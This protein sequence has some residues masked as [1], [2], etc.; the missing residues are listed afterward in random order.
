MHLRSTCNFI[1]Y[2][3]EVFKWTIKTQAEDS[4]HDEKQKNQKLNNLSKSEDEEL[5]ITNEDDNK[6][7]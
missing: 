6:E 4:Q 2:K 5:W 7:D 1:K 3:N